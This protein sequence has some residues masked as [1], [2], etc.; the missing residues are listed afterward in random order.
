[1]PERNEYIPGTPNWIDLQTS[2]Q[3]AA[4]SFYGSLFGWTFDD[5][6]I[7]ENTSYS[8]AMLKDRQ[9]AAIAP[10][11]DMAAQGVP[12]H[13]NSYISVSDVDA[14]AALVAPAGGTVMM[15][16]FDVMDA[17]RMCVIADPTGAVVNV[18]QAKN[19]IGAGIVNE[20]GAWSWNEL[21]TDDVPKAAAFY[22]KVF[23][24]TAN[25][26]G[27]D[28]NYTELKLGGDSI[29][30]A[31]NPPMPGIPNVWGIYFSVDDCD[32]TVEKAKS[33]GAALFAGPNDIEPGRFAVLADPQGAMFSVIKFKG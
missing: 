24:W 22:N 21:I 19:N 31:M 14:T 16:P 23:G 9:A 1:M 17:G 30:G 25:D 28:A 18:W 15:P 10:L 27:P 8:M 26:Y 33:L 32:A 6:P 7:D 29:A 3:K 20:A 4:K 13:W 12:P 5:L 11:G 2:D